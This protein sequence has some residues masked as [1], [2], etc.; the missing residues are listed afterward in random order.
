MLPTHSYTQEAFMTRRR[1][2]LLLIFACI[3]APLA[4]AAQPVEKVWRIGVL[5]AFCRE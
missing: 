1:I 4:A 2:G 5:Q 3:M